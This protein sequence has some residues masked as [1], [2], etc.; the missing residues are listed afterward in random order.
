MT[1]QTSEQEDTRLSKMVRAYTRIRDKRAE[2]KKAYSAED[3]A[4]SE[5]MDLIKNAL[6][7][8]CRET[9][10]ESVRTKDGLFYRTKKSTFWTSDWE[11]MHKFVL[12]HNEPDLLERRISQKHLREFLEENPDLM[13]AGLQAK[14]EYTVSV[15]KG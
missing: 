9:G 5:Q 4:L 15:R 12:E 2:I 11:S 7:D 8:H 6:L 10:A 14:T 1:E 3:G 13:P